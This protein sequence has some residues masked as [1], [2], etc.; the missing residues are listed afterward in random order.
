MRRFNRKKKFGKRKIFRRRRFNR[1]RRT[2]RL[3]KS[4]RG[5]V[6]NFGRTRHATLRYSMPVTLDSGAG[7]TS[8]A[9]HRVSINDI[10]SPDNLNVGSLSHQ[11]LGLDTWL[12]NSQGNPIYSQFIVT[13]AKIVVRCVSPATSVGAPSLVYLRITNNAGTVTLPNTTTIVE[14]GSASWRSFQNVGNG[15]P[16]RLTKGASMRKITGVKDLRDNWDRFGGDFANGPAEQYYFE[17][18][19]STISDD[20]TT[21]PPAIDFWYDVWYRVIFFNNNDLGQ[22]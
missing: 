4:P 15:M 19:C 1:R 7:I 17:F 16:I 12:G 18:G 20:N 13:G 10:R 2:M 14:Q 21:N 8:I 9:I 5:S 11:P 6:G 22:S 3:Y